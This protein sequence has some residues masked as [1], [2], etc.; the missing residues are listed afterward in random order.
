MVDHEVENTLREIRERVLAGSEQAQPA[1]PLATQ[2]EGPAA[3]GVEALQAAQANGRA[4]GEALARL[5]ANLST[6]ERAWSRLPPLLSYRRGLS[7]RLELWAKQQ[8]KRALHWFTWEQVNFNSA[9]HHALGDAR[10]ALS[11]HEQ[12]LAVHE[13]KLSAYERTLDAHEQ[14]AARALAEIAVLG[15]SFR[16]LR[17]EADSERA[18]LSELQARLAAAES[19]FDGAL[20]QLRHALAAGVEQLRAEHSSFAEGARADQRTLAE[21]L[22]DE[23][24]AQVQARAAELQ[25]EMYER[26]ERLLGEQRVCFKQLA[27]EAGEAA[28]THDRARR[29]IEARL[30]ALEQ[31]RER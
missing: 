8:I 7:A 23:Q 15:D 25:A 16:Q 12:R 31:N 5:Q 11:A 20:A 14:A 17:S 10:D 9:V 6:T 1:G 3:N 13:Q 21:G 26:A 22:R 2:P 28:V 24:R 4:S 18:R 19:R 30:D 29:Q 27:L